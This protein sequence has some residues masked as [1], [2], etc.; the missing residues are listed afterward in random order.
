MYGTIAR[1]KAKPEA[2]KTIEAR[3]RWGGEGVDGFIASYVYK[4]DDDPNEFW[5]AVLFRD[6]E[7]YFANANSPE[8][9]ERYLELRALLAEE[10]EWHD[11][12]VVTMNQS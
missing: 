7:S 6:R 4:S 10:P 9:N 1:M 11:G 2:V 8:Q 5:V 12:E 3:K